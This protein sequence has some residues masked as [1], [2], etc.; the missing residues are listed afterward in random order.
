MEDWLKSV[1]KQ[2]KNKYRRYRDLSIFAFA[3]MY[4]VAAIDAYCDA[5][6]S[7]FD[8]SPDLAFKI[9]PNIMID[10]RGA[11]SAGFSLA[12]NF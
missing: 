1:F 3:G 11:P 6:L 10:H 4:I 9:E 5:E 7:H 12:L 2:R 8:I